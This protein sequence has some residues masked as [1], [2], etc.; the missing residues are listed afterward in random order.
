MAWVRENALAFGG[1][2]Q[3]ITLGGHSAGARNVL[4]GLISPL[5]GGLFQKLLIVSGGR[6]LC[7]LNTAEDFALGIVG[8]LLVK[9]RVSAT[10]KA[11]RRYLALTP[12]GQIAAYL[13]GKR[14]EDYL[15]FLG[16]VEI[17]MADFPHLFKD[18]QVIP[19]DGFDLL[20]K[21]EYCRVPVILGSDATEY[22][23]YNV[24]DSYWGNSVLDLSI[25][26]DAEKKKLYLK[27]L[28]YGSRL[29][30]CLNADSTA[31]IL[32]ADSKQPPVYVY[33]FG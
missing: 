7:E 2:P 3:N 19:S 20:R 27:T 25:V 6:T 24:L 11:A 23:V 21:G 31:E 22:A 9:D 16:D 10:E 1:D 14:A 5:A 12:S 13:R 8:K 18:G 32:T 15:E 28:D 29:F 33:R 17:R 4:T 30:A 26:N